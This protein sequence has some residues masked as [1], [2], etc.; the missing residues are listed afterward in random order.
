MNDVLIA[1]GSH[2]A[3]ESTAERHWPRRE[4]RRSVAKSG[5]AAPYD[6][7]LWRL[8]SRRVAGDQAGCTIGVVGAEPR[9]GAT[10]VAANLAV[11]ACE[12]QQGPVLLI[13]AN[14][15]RPKLAG[16]WKLAGA[17]G[18]PALVAGGASLNDCV[19]V[20]PAP[21]L[22]VLTA[23]AATE[24]PTWESATVNALLAEVAA[25]YRVV[26]FDLPAAGQLNDSLLLARQ[27][28]Q[29]LLVVRAEQSR[30]PAVQRVA[31]QLADDGVSLAGVVLNRQRTYVPRWLSR[32]V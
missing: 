16:S 3:G 22:K 14:P 31:D 10:T 5:A 20:G 17:P 12:L 2:H 9:V 24:L 1:N 4:R 11:R 18:L 30:G 21:D 32:W 25:D 6:A 15:S 23:A 26:I 28:E 19:Q 8:L 27:L 29:V 7:L 13:E